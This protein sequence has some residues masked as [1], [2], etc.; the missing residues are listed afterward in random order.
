[1][2]F[3]GPQN[4]RPPDALAHLPKNRLYADQKPMFKPFLMCL[5]HVQ[6]LHPALTSAL[7]DSGF[8]MHGQL[9]LFCGGEPHTLRDRT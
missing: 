4:G 7:A 3:Y 1:M 8:V 9:P 5:L 6:R 2:L